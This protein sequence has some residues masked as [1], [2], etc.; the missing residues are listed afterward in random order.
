MKNDIL[1]AYRELSAYYK[2]KNVIVAVRSSATAEDLAG[3]SFAGAHETYLNID[4][5]AELLQAVKKMFWL[6]YFWSA[7]LFIVPKRALMI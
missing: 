6:L 5:P 7:L 3:A 1:N 2:T 4:T